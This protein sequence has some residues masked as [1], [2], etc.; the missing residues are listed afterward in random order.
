M[1][2]KNHSYAKVDQGRINSYP[3]PGDMLADL[4][5]AFNFYDKAG[6][7]YISMNHF[8]II[9]HN[10]GF[11]RL[12]KKEQDEELKRADSDFLK[13]TAV[14]FDVVKYVIGYRWNKSGREAEKMSQ[15]V[16]QALRQKGQG[17]N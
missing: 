2:P 11:R 14:T 15:R 9:L 5:D 10:F 4:Q 12:S 7:H 1:P 6:D 16:L 17:Y 13:R 3:L 8:R